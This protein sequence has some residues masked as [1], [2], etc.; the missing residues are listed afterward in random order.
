MEKY[1]SLDTFIYF[2]IVKIKPPY[3]YEKESFIL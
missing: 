3:P 2:C 1:D